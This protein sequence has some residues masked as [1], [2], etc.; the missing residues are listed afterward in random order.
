MSRLIRPLSERFWEKVAV[1]G[2]DDCWLWLAGVDTYGYGNISRP[3]G[4]KGSKMAHRVAWELAGGSMPDGCV[5]THTC[6][7]PRCVNP[8][9]LVPDTYSAN[10]Q[11]RY[12]R[13]TRSTVDLDIPRRPRPPRVEQVCPTCGSF[14]TA[15]AGRVARGLD[16]F[17]RRECIRRPLAD[18]F[19]EKVEKTDTCWVWVGAKTPGGYGV[20]G[21]GGKDGVQ[22]TAHRISW[23]LHF[24]SLPAD[25]VVCHRCDVRACVR[26]DHL[27]LGTQAENLTD[28]SR[29][30]RLVG[31][32][33]LFKG[34][35][36]MNAK[37]T[38][39]DV[40]AIRTRWAAGEKPPAL[41]V[42]YGV[43][44]ALI[45]AVVQRK[46]WKHVP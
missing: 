42:D 44:P 39:A 36:S 18:R 15:Q 5:L 25:Q 30:G 20:I 31:N 12:L 17:C 40:V 3:P 19:W 21:M 11:Q 23:E 4:D 7:Q 41:A 8:A 10:L 38:E 27:F 45:Y 34:E 14:F 6:D 22:T 46:A 26:P 13:A 33:G 2:P 29:K 37:L 35:A 32:R 28:A 24:G 16:R 1:A 43:S 9:H